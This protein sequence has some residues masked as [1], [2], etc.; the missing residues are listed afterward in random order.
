ME[1][2]RKKTNYVFV[3]DISCS[4]MY[5]TVA[6]LLLNNLRGIYRGIGIISLFFIEQHILPSRFQLFLQHFSCVVLSFFLPVF[7][8]VKPSVIQVPLP[9]L[10]FI[11]SPLE[12][13]ARSEVHSSASSPLCSP[14]LHFHKILRDLTY[15]YTFMNT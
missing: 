1:K 11:H 2:V 6:F 12:T 3:L 7:S 9:S 5:I 14:R 15:T 13:P 4:Y 8:S 10:P